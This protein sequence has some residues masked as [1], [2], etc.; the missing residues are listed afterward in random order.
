LLGL[1]ALQIGAALSTWKG[2]SFGVWFGIPVAGLNA[3]AALMSIPAYPFFS[4][5]IFAL[6]IVTIWA[7]ASYGGQ[8]RPV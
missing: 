4:L 3:I 8:G 2:G 6:D 7:L 1:G 5:A